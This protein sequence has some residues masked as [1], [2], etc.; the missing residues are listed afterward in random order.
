[1]TRPLLIVGV[2]RA[3]TVEEAQIMREQIRARYSDLDL[4]IIG[5]CSSLAVLE[6]EGDPS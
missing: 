2:D 6:L 3:L 1:V 5:S 4:L